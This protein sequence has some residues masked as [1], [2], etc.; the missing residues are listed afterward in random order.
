MQMYEEPSK[1]MFHQ[2]I[3][4]HQAGFF[5][6][7][8]KFNLLHTHSSNT[9]CVTNNQDSSPSSSIVTK[10]S[11]NQVIHLTSLMKEIKYRSKT[12]RVVK[13]LFCVKFK[14]ATANHMDC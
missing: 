9:S 8:N 1:H 2:N 4:L 12:K 5:L 3:P 14:M 10:I 11:T 7:P 6:I 13:Y